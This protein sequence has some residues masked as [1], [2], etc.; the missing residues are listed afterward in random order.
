MS[1]DAFVAWDAGALQCVKRGTRMGYCEDGLDVDVEIRALEAEMAND[2]YRDVMN[3]LSD[4]YS[5]LYS[6]NDWD[7]GFVDGP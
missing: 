5:D 3:D 7:G 4:A 6:G 2:L 1:P